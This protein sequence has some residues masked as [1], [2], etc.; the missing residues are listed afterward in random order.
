MGLFGPKPLLRTSYGYQPPPNATAHGWSCTNYDCG[1][2]EHENVWLWPHS[3]P[4]CGSPT[5]PLFDAPWDH[6]AEGVELQHRIRTHPERGSYDREQWELWLFKDAL[7]RHDPQRVA[8]S[9][10]RTRSYA[11]ARSADPRWTPVHF[12]FHFVWAALDAGDLNGAAS[13][14]LYW[15]SISS[16]QDVE[17]N[18]ERRTNC[19][20]IIMMAS[21]FLEVQRGSIHPAAPE[22][23]RGCLKIAERAYEVLQ[24]QQQTAVRQMAR[25]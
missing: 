14:L 11:A 15:M 9:R 3:C 4:R 7:L 13:D 2:A 10:A 17:T 21:R 16:T 8:E 1:A 23:R 24:P 20:Q 6:E 5:D 22:I 25:F 12:Y 19:R 18:N